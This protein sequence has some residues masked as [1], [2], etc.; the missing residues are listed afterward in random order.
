M[1]EWDA[2][3]NGKHI[4]TVTGADFD[5]ALEN[6]KIYA[7]ETSLN[8]TGYIEHTELHQLCGCGGWNDVRC[9]CN[10]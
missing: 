6:F 2:L 5:E 9:D 3:I 10:Y 1:I 4:T 8:Y 7:A